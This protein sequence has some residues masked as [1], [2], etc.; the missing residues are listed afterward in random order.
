MREADLSG[1]DCAGAVMTG[2]DL[3]GAQMVGA[4]MSGCDLRGSDLTAFNPTLMALDGAIITP[5]QA[6]I[7][8][9]SLGLL[10]QP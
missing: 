7:I 6:M 9:Q 10:I 1:T 2:V 3:S 8:A 5:E 4:T